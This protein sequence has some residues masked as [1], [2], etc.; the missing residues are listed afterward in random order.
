MTVKRRRPFGPAALV[1][2]L[3]LF[4][5]TGVEASPSIWRRAARP[6]V[7]KEAWLLAGLE[8]TL[9]AHELLSG[10][11]AVTRDMARAAVAMSEISGIRSPEDPRLACVMAQAL[12]LADYGRQEDA[13]R[14]LERALET[15]PV[16]PLRLNALRRLGVLLAEL[17]EPRLSRETYT[18]ALELAVFPH[19]RANLYYNRAEASLELDELE[20]ADADYRRAI[21]LASEPDTLAL[22][23]YG[24]AVALERSG[25]LPAAFTELDAALAITL[26]VPVYPVP[27]PLELPDVFFVPAYERHYLEALRSMARLRHADSRAR[28]LVEA[29]IALAAWDAY[30]A[31]APESVRYRKNAE[32][33]RRRIAEGMKRGN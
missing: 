20:L 11:P 3:A 27:D 28:Y 32:A 18:Q 19:H 22:A 13:R 9:D 10:E 15:L 21:E 23:R 24:L 1:C 17:A 25:D 5:A 30:L 14:L 7:A 16:G 4:V 29:A 33:Y 31:A 2:A 6:Q 26:P 12:I 8:R